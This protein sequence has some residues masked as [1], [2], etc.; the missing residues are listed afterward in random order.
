[1]SERMSKAKELPMFSEDWRRRWL[2]L[3]SW[4]RLHRV[5]EINWAESETYGEGVTAC[6]RR[7][8]LHIPGILSRMGLTRCA[9][10]CRIAGVP[11]GDGAPFNEGTEE[12]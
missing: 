2:V 6:G 4:N 10:C 12:P 11:L 3:P 9:H 1:M 7:G 8:A 5:A